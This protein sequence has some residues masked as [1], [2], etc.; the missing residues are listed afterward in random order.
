[1]GQKTV[2][3]RGFPGDRCAYYVLVS[4]PV[5][6][7]QSKIK[8]IAVQYYRTPHARNEREEVVSFPTEIGIRP[9]LEKLYASFV[10][11]TL[12]E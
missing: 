10:S 1:M 11:Y 2:L 12:E 6:R 4:R 5:L 7:G 8:K 3:K 9:I